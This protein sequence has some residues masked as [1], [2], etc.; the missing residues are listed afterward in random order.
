MLLI[1]Q[2]H[3]NNASYHVGAFCLSEV[4]C[5]H[6][7]AHTHNREPRLYEGSMCQICTMQLTRNSLKRYSSNHATH[8]KLCQLDKFHK[9]PDIYDCGASYVIS[10]PRHSIGLIS[11]ERGS[12]TFS[13]EVSRILG[14]Y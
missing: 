13:P 2:N 1:K 6:T 3:G 10:P 8:C 4:Q 7:H 9:L 5:T 14:I 12:H 11:G